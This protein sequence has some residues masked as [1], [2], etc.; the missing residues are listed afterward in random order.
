L[1][2]DVGNSHTKF[3]L[4]NGDSLIANW[5]LV[6][7]SARTTDELR[8]MLTG[9]LAQEGISPRAITGVCIAS[10]VPPVNPMIEV[11]C[12]SI[13][14]LTPLFVVPGVRTGIT[15]KVENPKEVG[16]DRIVNSVAAAEAYGGPLIV[17]DLGTATKFEVI[18]ENAEYLG[19]LIAPGIQISADALFERCAKLARVEI[20]V[21]EHVIGKNTVSHIR[22][23]LTFGPA[24]MVDGLIG[25]IGAEMRATPTVIAT[26]GFA[27][28]IGPL[29][30][31]IDHIDPLLTLKGLRAVFV[32]NEKSTV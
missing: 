18:S 23:G 15:I 17:V 30:K 20:A 16:A 26:G 6:T 27:P 4:F 14:Q 31:R 7:T 19:G 11:M 25:R 13:F 3:G 2:M 32:K 29:C 8:V 22:A 10:V 5:R 21:P 1:V 12:A 28:L 9:L 24:E